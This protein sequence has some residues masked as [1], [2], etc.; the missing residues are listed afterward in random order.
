[1][2]RVRTHPGAIALGMQSLAEGFICEGV[3]EGIVLPVMPHAPVI[4]RVLRLLASRNPVLHGDNPAM[5]CQNLTSASGF[6]VVHTYLSTVH[7]SP[8]S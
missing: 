3:Y 7:S 6:F 5:Q 1:M 4:I 2:M 8:L